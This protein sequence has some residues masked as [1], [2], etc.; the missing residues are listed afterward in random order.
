MWLND[1]MP[2][3]DTEFTCFDIFF[4]GQLLRYDREGTGRDSYDTL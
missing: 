2:S 3:N 1:R 4:H